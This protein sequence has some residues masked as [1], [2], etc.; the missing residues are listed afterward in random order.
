MEND[1]LALLDIRL[2]RTAALEGIPKKG[3]PKMVQIKT[4][5]NALVRRDLRQLLGD[6]F[7]GLF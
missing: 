5:V 4:L 2:A 1:V 6:A 3:V 7:D